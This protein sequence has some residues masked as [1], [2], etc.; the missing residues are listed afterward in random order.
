M[1]LETYILTYRGITDS[2]EEGVVCNIE[3]Y[4]ERYIR[5]LKDKFSEHTFYGNRLVVCCFHDDNDPSMGLIKHRH[6]K[7]VKVFHCFGCGTSGNV[8]RMHQLVQEKY[9]NRSISQKDAC[10]ELAKLFG[11]P[12][13]DVENIE[14]DYES[15]Y[16]FNLKKIDR[17]KRGYT[18]MD[19]K[20]TLLEIRKTSK[21]GTKEILE[22]VNRESIKMIA[23]HKRLYED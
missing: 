23:T 15:K 3:D 19:Y 1:K 13:E 16:L 11:I 6:L 9:Y 2:G 10:Y 8:I 17:L 18:I 7:D 20:D 4:Y 21:K 12:V 5:N 22:R 14:E